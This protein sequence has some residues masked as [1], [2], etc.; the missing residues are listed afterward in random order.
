MRVTLLLLAGWIF[1]PMLGC[2]SLQDV[3]YDL[4]QR[5]RVRSEWRSLPD[6]AKQSNSPIDYQ[7]G[8]KDG[9]YEVTTGGS[10][11]P[12]VVAPHHYWR[13]RQVI[14]LCDSRR[15]A[16]YSGFQDGAAHASRFPD[17]HHLRAWGSCDCPLP[18]CQNC[19]DSSCGCPIGSCGMS[20]SD[21][22]PMPMTQQTLPVTMPATGGEQVLESAASQP[23][24]S[25]AV[26]SATKT[27]FATDTKVAEQMI[28]SASFEQSESAALEFS[29][30][31][32]HQTLPKPA[33]NAGSRPMVDQDL[34][35]TAIVARQNAVDS[36]NTVQLAKTLDAARSASKPI[37][38]AGKSTVIQ[39]T[40]FEFQESKSNGTVKLASEIQ[41][42]E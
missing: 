2:A 32:Q 1:V 19:P 42:P 34:I 12:P 29:I 16:Y 11:C 25:A 20:T 7:R 4:S 17:T 41:L 24:A 5:S 10:S 36:T 6:R 28:E 23:L 15:N 27:A 39:A 8:W 13:P 35:A 38:T 18:S 14:N 37:T 9:F 3:Q 21:D 30:L 33:D 26:S 22:T 31:A 40:P